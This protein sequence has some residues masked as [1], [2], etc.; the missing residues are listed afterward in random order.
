[1]KSHEM[2]LFSSV[3]HRLAEIIVLHPTEIGAISTDS[4]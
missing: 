2:L 1:M 3:V 4:H